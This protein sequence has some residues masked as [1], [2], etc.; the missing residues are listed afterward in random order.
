MNPF[1]FFRHRIA[2]AAFLGSL[3]AGWAPLA[4]SQA[5]VEMLTAART[6]ASTNGQAAV[7]PSAKPVGAAAKL[8][9]PA[10]QAVT[11]MDKSA[12]AEIYRKNVFD[13]KRQPWAVKS[14]APPETSV[15]PITPADAEVYGVMMFGDYKKAIIKLGQGF[16]FAPQ[17]KNK[18]VPRPFVTLGVGES[19]GP[20]LLTEINEKNVVFANGGAQFSLAFTHKKI[21]RPLAAAATPMA[22]APVVLP[23]PTPTIVQGIEPI[24]DMPAA[25]PA[26]PPAAPAVE[27]PVPAAAPPPAPAAA[28][29]QTAAAPATA[30]PSTNAAAAPQIQGMSLLDAI[31]AAQ[32]AKK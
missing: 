7:P 17:P 3:C 31:Q 24:V 28:A 15:T 22:Q 21:D 32:A 4:G 25:A 13:S 2:Q 26:A 9:E 23:A 14:D 20:Y 12:Y 30:A 11:N 5:L 18:G 10:A 29:P 19:L 27:Q 8:P 16:K 1:H 6:A